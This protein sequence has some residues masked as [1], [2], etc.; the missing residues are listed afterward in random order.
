MLALLLT[1]RL[2]LAGPEWVDPAEF[3]PWAGVVECESSGYVRIENPVSTA[4]GLFQFLDTTWDWVTADA[5]RD[6][7]TGRPAS[8]ASVSDQYAMA[9]HLRDMPGGGIG[10][11]ECGYRYK[12]GLADPPV[13][14][15][16]G[17]VKFEVLLATKRYACGP[18]NFR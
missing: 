6:D 3:G 7:L 13:S 1:T 5:G 12:R 15:F 11:W 4:S 16:P 9:L 17:F 18:G 2:L 10:H 14:V 8:E